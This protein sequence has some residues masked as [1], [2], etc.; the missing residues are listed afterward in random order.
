MDGRRPSSSSHRQARKEAASPYARPNGSPAPRAA[1]A[2]GSS[3]P[4]RLGAMLSFL[5]PFRRRQTPA[6]TAN[7]SAP[8]QRLEPPSAHREEPNE[9]DEQSHMSQDSDEDAQERQEQLDERE[10]DESTYSLASTRTPRV[11]PSLPT[12]TPSFSMP[13]LIT[14]A[15]TS[16]GSQQQPQ[17][18]TI[19]G[20]DSDGYS[21][22][23]PQRAN[24]ELAN[25]F[26]EKA[27]RDGEPLTPIEQAGVLH[28][29]QQAQAESNLSTAFTPNFKAFS[30]SQSL[31]SLPR[32]ASLQAFP[33]SESAFGSPGAA[34][35]SPATGFRRRR[36]IY[37]GAGYSS[38]SARRRRTANLA[39]DALSHSQSEAS[40]SSSLT[41]SS[42]VIDGKRRKMDDD[43]H[44]NELSAPPTLSLA[45]QAPASPAASTSTAKTTGPGS[46]LAVSSATAHSTP[47]K[48]S[49]LWQVSKAATPSPSP[50]KSVSAHA[51]ELEQPS[52]VRA[53]TRAADIVMGV[54][55]ED[56]K[57]KAV[58]R[59]EVLN[60]YDSVDSPM[61]RIPRSRPVKPATPRRTPA[62]KAA[63]TPAPAAREL[64]AAEQLE[65]TMPQEYRSASAKRKKVDKP[66]SVEP[67]PEP[68]AAPLPVF[69]KA[70][71]K[72]VDKPKAKKKA[73]AAPVEM[74]ELSDS[75]EQ[76]VVEDE[77]T[78][79]TIS[80]PKAKKAHADSAE[81]ASAKA[82]EAQPK[83]ASMFSWASAASAPNPATAASATKPSSGFSFAP[84]ATPPDQKK[85]QVSVEIASTKPSSFSSTS[86]FSFG[87]TSV[88]AKP[89]AALARPDSVAAEST[90]K[91]AALPFASAPKSADA[92]KP[93]ESAA[94]TSSAPAVAMSAPSAAF[95]RASTE[96]KPTTEF[97]P[98]KVDANTVAASSTMKEA[99]TDETEREAALAAAKLTL[100]RVSFSD[101]LKG[102]ETSAGD[103]SLRA[104][105]DVVLAMSKS[106]LPTFAL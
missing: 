12:I 80:K 92:P 74:M 31:S 49:P 10:Q 90:P 51:V 87:S 75:D 21:R 2:T 19:D 102:C 46:R 62:K 29:M 26:R 24:E 36:P 37:V 13:N 22:T 39:A 98:T 67:T 58:S 25:F 104:V 99:T 47:A 86:S 32:S 71:G 52:P 56:A 103:G 33:T 82:V 94:S 43:E 50:A 93:S 95:A 89:F 72:Q 65:K 106:E 97:A 7:D 79:P 48:P 57:P 84:S 8:I 20:T 73:E 91:S 53:P 54:L 100:P 14:A 40:L 38:A 45:N 17:Q 5:S 78:P 34:A 60:P 3:T 9:H 41:G 88:S 59:Q 85:H 18:Q 15:S 6:R 101:A 27:Q 11:Y 81:S 70:S 63:P 23:S 42:A 35:Q 4:S 68:E 1:A 28:L 64:S 77:Q 55:K 105:M 61:P 30:A 66:A 69:K 83:Q 44:D 96:S 76:D 16:R